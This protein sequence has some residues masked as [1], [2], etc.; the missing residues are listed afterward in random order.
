M[1]MLEEEK[2]KMPPGTRLMPEH[3]RLETLNDLFDSK[4]EIN[5]ALE[6]LPVMSKTLQM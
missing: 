6:K 2:S 3:E 4:K 5:T 1:R